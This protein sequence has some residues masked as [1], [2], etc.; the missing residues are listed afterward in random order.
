[1]SERRAT[2]AYAAVENQDWHAAAMHAEAAW[3]GGYRP[4]SQLLAMIRH[5]QRDFAGAVEAIERALR[6]NELGADGAARL[7]RLHLLAGDASRAWQ[8]LR[9]CCRHNVFGPPLYPLPR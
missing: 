4:A 9:D 2:L 6:D 8:L 7:I 1:M 5:K 3:Q